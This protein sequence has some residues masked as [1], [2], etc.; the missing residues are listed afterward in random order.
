MPLRAHPVQVDRHGADRLAR[1][2]PSKEDDH[3]GQIPLRLAIYGGQTDSAVAAASSGSLRIAVARLLPGHR[4]KR[5]PVLVKIIDEFPRPVRVI[6]N[7]WV[8][9]SDGCRLALRIWLP[10]DAESDPVPAIL[11]CIPYRKRDFTRLRDEPMH[12]YFAGH[13]YAAVRMDLRGSG[14]SDGLLEDEYLEQEHDDVLEVIEWLASQPWCSGAVGMMGISWGGFNAL[15]LAARRPAALKAILTLC[16]TDDRYTDDAHYAGG[17]LLNENLSWGSVFLSCAASPPDPAIVGDRWREM[18]RERVEKAV[19]Y[20]AVWMRHPHRDD[21]WKHGSVCEDFDSIECPV[22]AVGG[23]ADGYSNAIPR[24]MAGLSAPR[25]ALIGPWS[26]AFPHNGLPG[27]AIG[28]F[29]EALRWWDCWLKGID[30]G[31]MDEPMIRAWLAEYA[32]PAPSHVEIPGRWVAETEWPPPCARAR[33][34][35]LNVL[36]LDDAPG[37]ERA[38]MRTS[39]QTTGLSAG[40]WYGFGADGESPID[41]R[42]DDGKSL[43][44]DTEPLDERIEILGAPVVELELEVDQPVAHVVV[45]L[46][47]VAP[48][49]AS[50]RVSWGVLDLAHRNTHES[51]DAVE[52][53]RRYRIR[54]QLND[55]GYAFAPGHTIRVAVSTCYWPVIWPTPAPVRLTLFAGMGQL[56]LPVR[57]EAAADVD[58]RPFD[59]PEAG[60]VSDCT[61]LRE[62]GL[63][64]SIERDLTT[65]ETVY[66]VFGDD[67]KARLEDI[68]L[69]VSYTISKTYRIHEYDP[70]AA[71]AII[72]QNTVHSRGDWSIRLECRTSLVADGE[73]FVL[74]ASLR[75]WIDGEPFVARD[76]DEEIPRPRRRSGYG[77]A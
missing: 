44:F 67:A 5:H 32:P 47:D 61:T 53:G 2:A 51:P 21:Y 77:D 4:K 49:G 9:A 50:S 55:I 52:P 15:Q 40:D 37:P 54:V 12:H 57:P 56:E 75:T 38:L 10:E 69:T 28:F 41:Q 39:P 64:R 74:R 63:K 1:F 7:Q 48:D 3:S 17:C 29:Q 33:R 20:P 24:L 6:E 76:W 60:P 14:D 23:W 11:E 43:T 13:G 25:K 66:R 73:R 34:W 42:E 31:I 46:N 18:W 72:E 65:N 16:S 71:E 19:L 45:R 68:D 70:S 36:S 27:P 35:Y 26:H 62:G 22:Y 59:R 30:T 58:L 8:V